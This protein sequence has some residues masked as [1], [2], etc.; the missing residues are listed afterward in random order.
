MLLRRIT[1]DKLLYFII[2]A[3]LI[4][5]YSSFIL[6][7][8]FIS[9][10]FNWDK[11]N[12]N[13]DRIYRLQLFMDQ[14]EN[15]IK[16]TWSVTAGLSR[17]ELTEF[18]EIEKIV[19]IHD[20]GDNNKS[21]V[22]LSVDKENQLL[23]R[24]GYYA[25]QSAFDVFTF[26]FIEGDPAQALTQPYS[27]VLSKE[28]A[29]KL[30]Q[31]GGALGRQVYGENKVAF[32]VT[33][34]YEDIPERST[35]RPV[36]LLPMLSYTALTGDK[37]YENNYFGY[38]F[39]TYVM[40]KPGADPLSIDKQI[41]DAL[42]DFRKEHH[43]YLRPM[44]KL[45]LNP[46]FDPSLLIAISLI[47]FLS[48]LILVLTSI[49]FINLQTANATNRLR[50]I[51]IKKTLGFSKK[52]LWL[53]VIIETMSLTFVAALAGI[54]VAQVA[55]PSLNN[56]FSNKI[57]TFPD[58]LENKKLIL[59][60]FAVTALTG[61]LSGIHPAYVISSYNPVAA[62]KT[63]YIVDKSNGVSLKKVLVT[64]QFSISVFI[65]IVAFIIYRQTEYMLKKDLGFN[66]STVLF[67][68]I[69]TDKKGSFEPLRRNLLEHS[70]IRDACI[71]DYIPFILPGGDDLHWDGAAPD[72]KVFVRFSRVS[73][74]FVPTFGLK[75]TKG[76]NFSK[77]F[78]SDVNSCLINETAER[79]FSWSD[80]I[81]KR[82]RAY[83]K[84][85]D[86]V[87][88]IRDYTA[89]S[90]FNPIEP[91][92]YTLLPDSLVSNAV[93]AVSFAEGKE[94]EALRAVNE[95][96]QKFM[97][98]D[99]YDFRNIQFLVQNE[100]AV[101][102]FGS[103]RKLTGLIALL[104]II[105]SSIGLFGLILFMT[106]KKMKEIGIRKV[107][108]FSFGNLYITL[109]S[110]FIKLMVISLAIAWPAAYYVYK[111]LPGSDKYS[112]QVW[113]FLVA[114]IIIMIV[115]IATISYQIIKALK[116][117]PVEILKDE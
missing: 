82:I 1:K 65:L 112:L 60:I 59:I 107:L 68:N 86:V 108:G 109:S 95:E 66:S 29:T 23:T 99:A 75:M 7:S 41:Y 114:T 6:I 53:Q 14:E 96:F 38:S 39:Y 44:S 88:V 74:D 22:F 87:G 17:K 101:T 45:N 115:A 26:K 110:W 57:F 104:T 80:P 36:Y 37:N 27:I 55:L 35:W 77:E 54:V 42:K 83:G 64:I 9:G 92:L 19:L 103:L 90:V 4:V 32:T 56:I 93:Y 31:G 61:F 62:L 51:G 28:L 3:N 106:Q 49:N 116:V 85:Y 70:E 52:Q 13:Y 67:S 72:E 18:P 25:D 8:Q 78:T 34:V 111:V 100:N 97:P 94:Q 33:G 16:H 47:G 63:K 84:E 40:L 11:Y 12:T 81:G 50:E 24:Y 48:V 105:I 43:P 113:E 76:R 91:H 15:A 58:I 117:K 10:E 73:Y 46:F 30:F 89:F 5:G 71:A 2:F 98:E 102:A 69:V 21:G 20:V 79:V